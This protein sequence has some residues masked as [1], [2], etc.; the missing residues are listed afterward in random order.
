MER[1]ELRR[2]VGWVVGEMGWVGEEGKDRRGGG[3]R[4]EGK[5][6]RAG[7]QGE[8]ENGAPSVRVSGHRG[9]RSGMGQG[10][11]LPE[12]LCPSQGPATPRQPL[13]VLSSLGAWSSMGAGGMPSTSTI[14]FIWST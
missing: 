2:V 11:H 9:R 8:G 14:R 5:D 10:P 7:K 1:E 12:F 13:K 3:K 6:T 4:K